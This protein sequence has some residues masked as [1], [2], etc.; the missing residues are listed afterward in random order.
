MTTTRRSFAVLPARAA[1]LVLLALALV[2]CG[3]DGASPA[4]TPTATATV[5]TITPTPVPTSTA[6]PAP[7]TTPAGTPEPTP[8]ATA[9]PTPTPTPDERTLTPPTTGAGLYGILTVG[10]MC[11]VV[12]EGE[13]CP[14]RRYEGTLR[15]ES[16]SGQEVALVEANAEGE[17]VVELPAGSYR[18]VPLSPPGSP[19]PYAGPADAVVAVDA[20]TRLDIAY[21]SGIR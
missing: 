10:P 15:I 18:V 17:Y 12:R 1:A 6:T 7:G 9:S 4:A 20:W 14:D 13:P 8:S 21:D 3:T 11:P 19:L 5:P 16:R 2:G